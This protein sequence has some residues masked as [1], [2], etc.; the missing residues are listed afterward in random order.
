MKELLTLFTTAGLLL[1]AAAAF[2]QTTPTFPRVAGHM[3]LVHPIVTF[4][5]D[6]SHTNFDGVYVVG[7]PTAINIWKSPKL[8]FSFEAV[9][10]IRTENNVSK[11]SNFLFHPGVVTPL[12]KG[13]SFI[14]RAA[15]ETSG[16]FGLTPIVSKVVKK[17]AHSNYF[18]SVPFPVR[19]GNDKATSLGIAV[20]VAVGF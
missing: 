14:G 5:G 1:F 12:G 19:F 7:V 13:F 16:R 18:V 4:D 15:F 2:P 9:P 10:Y 6:G 8:A 17:N 20:Q 11:M 3:G